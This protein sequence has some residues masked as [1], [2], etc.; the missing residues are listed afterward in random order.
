MPEKCE[1]FRDL[2]A[3]ETKKHLI[4]LLL[5]ETLFNKKGQLLGIKNLAYVVKLCHRF[6]QIISDV[7]SF[8][9][10]ATIDG[11]TYVLSKNQVLVSEPSS[12]LSANYK[13]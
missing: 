11:T 2:V 6:L 7:A 4:I 12:F 13:K 9:K 3:S 1:N 5:Q 8:G 10:W